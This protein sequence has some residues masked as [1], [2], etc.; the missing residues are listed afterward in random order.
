MKRAQVRVKE[1]AEVQGYNIKTLSEKSGLAYPI[2]HKYWHNQ[3]VRVDL[4][5]LTSL[6]R[7]LQC[8]ETDL[9]ENS[10]P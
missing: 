8:K 4:G 6:A 3:V 5:T 1:V 7:A 9:I 10:S 2:V